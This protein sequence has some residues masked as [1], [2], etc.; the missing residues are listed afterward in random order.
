M[1]VS[2]FFSEFL[3]GG[4]QGRWNWYKCRWNHLTWDIPFTD[5]ERLLK[6]AQEH[7]ECEYAS[8]IGGASL[9]TAALVWFYATDISRALRVNPVFQQ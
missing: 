9:L 8:Y 7:F 2:P 1:I 4:L 5:T 3:G 6:V